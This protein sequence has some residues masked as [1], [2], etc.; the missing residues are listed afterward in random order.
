MALAKGWRPALP[1][2][3]HPEVTHTF[4]LFGRPT[5]GAALNPVV[6]ILEVGIA[7]GLPLCA[8]MA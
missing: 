4:R 5:A 6:R 8:V 2:F 3:R 7:S 1:D